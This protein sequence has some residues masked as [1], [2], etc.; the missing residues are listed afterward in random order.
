M[1]GR[2]DHHAVGVGEAVPVNI[3]A[4]TIEKFETERKD[5]RSTVFTRTTT[6]T[7]VFTKGDTVPHVS[8]RSASDVPPPGN[9]LPEMLR[10]AEEQLGIDLPDDIFRN[11]FS[12]FSSS[13][14]CMKGISFTRV[15]GKPGF[16]TVNGTQYNTI[17][18]IPD[19]EIRAMARRMAH[20]GENREGT[21]DALFFP[22]SGSV[23][24]IDPEQ[25]V[26]VGINEQLDPENATEGPETDQ[27]PPSASTHYCDRCRTNVQ[28]RKRF[29][30]GLKCELCG[31]KLE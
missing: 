17:E 30:G 10:M 26:E 11:D 23:I 21:E 22:G 13:A 28:G 31:S 12:S 18:D 29:F 3:M 19:E 24:E 15:N 14:S 8:D 6:T 2:I 25:A 4:D 5:G 9:D 7:R 27:P 1:G 20:Q 16:W